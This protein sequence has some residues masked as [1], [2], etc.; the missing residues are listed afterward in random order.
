MLLL[1]KVAI[2]AN[3]V[4]FRSEGLNGPWLSYQG[5]NTSDRRI[6]QELLDIYGPALLAGKL[7]ATFQG[8][9]VGL[10]LVANGSE[11]YSDL[12]L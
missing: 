3:I 4:V 10:C 12:D 9:G 11:D 6:S 2:S 7:A 1:S 8:L 5:Q